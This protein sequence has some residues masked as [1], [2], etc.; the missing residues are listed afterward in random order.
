MYRVC[1]DDSVDGNE[2]LSRVMAVGLTNDHPTTSFPP[3]FNTSYT[4]CAL[5][6]SH[7]YSR[8]ANAHT[9]TCAPSTAYSI[10]I[11]QAA[12]R[13]LCLAEVQ[14]YRRRKLSVGGVA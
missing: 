5:Q 2:D 11:V 8:V 13:I 12:A 7:E 14:V 6:N 3:V 9:Y 10:V 4:L 1:P